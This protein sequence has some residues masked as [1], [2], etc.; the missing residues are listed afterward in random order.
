MAHS[1]HVCRPAKSGWQ[2]VMIAKWRTITTTPIARTPMVYMTTL[3]AHGL[4]Q[5]LLAIPA[6]SRQ[7]QAISIPLQTKLFTLILP[8]QMTARIG[9]CKPIKTRLMRPTVLL[10]IP[11]ISLALCLGHMRR[12]GRYLWFVLIRI[13]PVDTK[14]SLSIQRLR[15]V[16]QNT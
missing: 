9:A 12:V 4:P 5:V 16:P 6:L 14:V 2:P 8:T 13:S 10:P 7:P 3:T 15:H 1:V 11:T